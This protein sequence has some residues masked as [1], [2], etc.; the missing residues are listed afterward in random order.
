MCFHIALCFCR[1]T[2]HALRASTGL[3]F[4]NFHAKLLAFKN[5]VHIPMIYQK[6][7]A[8]LGGTV[9]AR[10]MGMV[11]LAGLRGLRALLSSLD[12]LPNAVGIDGFDSASPG[13]KANL[14]TM[15]FMVRAREPWSYAAITSLCS[16]FRCELHLKS[17]TFGTMG[18]STEVSGP[19]TG[20]LGRCV[21]R[22]FLFDELL[23]Q[24]STCQDEW[25]GNFHLERWQEVLQ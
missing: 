12:G 21:I 8:N 23:L 13:M 7:T 9:L 18:V 25:D 3:I 5:S 22:I 2:T 14:R 24:S 20:P 4:I 10:S 11:H 1:Q 6:H 17:G 16:P 19:I 15:R